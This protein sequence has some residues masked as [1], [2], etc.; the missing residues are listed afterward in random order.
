MSLLK[1]F[2][3]VITLL[4]SLNATTVY[5]SD[6]D[7]WQALI[8]GKVQ[9]AVWNDN[10]KTCKYYLTFN[11][12]HSLFK[13]HVFCPLDQ[14]EVEEIGILKTQKKS[15]CNSSSHKYFS[16]VVIQIENGSIWYDELD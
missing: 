9:K 4:T 14:Q 11:D 1:S 16:G 7:N 13:S 8:I 3:I 15:E 10:T 12:Q 6:C 5:G 2:L